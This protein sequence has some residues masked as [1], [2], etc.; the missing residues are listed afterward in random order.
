M[1]ARRLLFLA[2]AD[3][4]G[5]PAETLPAGLVLERHA[6]PLGLLNALEPEL[7][8]PVLLWL[9]G[10]GRAG[11]EA[12][13]ELLLAL[14]ERQPGLSR[15]LWVA[16]DDAAGAAAGFESGA[17]QVLVG[18]PA[19]EAWRRR[20]SRALASCLEQEQDWR[21]RRAADNGSLALLAGTSAAVLQ[22]RQRL[23]QVAE[24]YPAPVLIR[25]EPGAGHA[26]AARALHELSPRAAGPFV[27]LDGAQAAGD[28]QGGGLFADLAGTPANLSPA[29][30]GGTLLLERPGELAPALQARLLGWLQERRQAPGG[31][32][33]EPR[34]EARLL[35]SADSD[36]DA[37]VAAGR[38]RADLYYRLNVLELWLP[39]LRERPQD[40]GALSAAI[41]ARLA[42]E[43]GSGPLRLS[44][45]GLAALE[46]ERWPGN[47]GE[48]ERR[49]RR[50]AALATGPELG[51]DEL[52]RA[53]P[54]SPTAPPPAPGQTLAEVERE[55]IQRVLRECGHNKSQAA[56]RLG[57]H[58][59]TL[60]AKLR[61][62]PVGT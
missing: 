16:G 45:A 38:L 36:L 8:E 58:R 23:S 48:L 56:R 49:L 14:S 61:D 25:G 44:A 55:Q 15:L 34:A 29:A 41:L 26:L 27:S 3:Q 37:Q 6:D 5:P 12:A 32:A 40:L 20:L 18:A 9:P 57:L 7:A 54:G 17:E 19:A 43:Q 2:P 33:I 42:R 11:R 28:P 59:S 53:T 4:A 39:P 30:R 46:Q 13:F 51:A 31:V 21:R 60:Y 1:S 22:L 62:L 35:V 24:A 10:P 50:A 47:L 52:C